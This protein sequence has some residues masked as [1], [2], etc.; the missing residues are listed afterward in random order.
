MDPSS[1]AA[2]VRRPGR[3]PRLDAGDLDVLYGLA[4]ENPGFGADN[5]AK[6][7]SRRL[8]KSV[9][10][11][12]V[13]VALV[14]A[15]WRRMIRPAA[16]RPEPVPPPPP[17]SPRY[18]ER[19]RI[20]AGSGYPSD[21]SDAEWA[22]LE[23]HLRGRRQRHPCGESTRA[24]VNAL[25]YMARTGCQWR[26]LPHEFPAW[27]TVAKTYYR[28]VARGT[29]EEVN[30]AL[31]REVRIAAGRDPEPT[32]AILDSQSVKTTEKG[33]S[34]GTTPERRSRDASAISSSIPS[35]SSSSRASMAPMSRTAKGAAR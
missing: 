25:L 11:N 1:S 7:L 20:E 21:L 24:T 23:P 29:W 17:D 26:F 2:D 30:A 19:H 15:G 35:A 8:G 34:A 27:N 4:R 10:D 6:L 22:L 13:R 5:L 31:R 16:E 9:S 3:P 28:W 32:A 18:T 14:R 12:T 33:G